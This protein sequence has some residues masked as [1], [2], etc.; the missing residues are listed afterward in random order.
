MNVNY[1]NNT[2]YIS[3]TV[4]NSFSVYAN[5]SCDGRAVKSATIDLRNNIFDGST[6]LV[7]NMT[8]ATENY[9]DVGGMQSNAGFSINGSSTPGPNDIPNGMVPKPDP[10]YVAPPPASPPD[11]HLQTGSP[12]INGGQSGLTGNN[13]MGAY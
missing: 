13:N 2:I 1:Y 10:L 11:F 6:I 8:S 12:C 4:P 7:T 9:N 5:G 3:S